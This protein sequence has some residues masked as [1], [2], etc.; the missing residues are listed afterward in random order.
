MNCSALLAPWGWKPSSRFVDLVVPLGAFEQKLASRFA[1][2][3][4]MIGLSGR[5]AACQGVDLGARIAFL[6]WRPASPFAESAALRSADPKLARP[7]FGLGP[8]G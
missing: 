6:G 8:Q 4:L 2:L 3:A 5:R 7:N 1:D